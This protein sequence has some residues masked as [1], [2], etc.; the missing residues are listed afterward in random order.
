MFNCGVLFCLLTARYLFSDMSSKNRVYARY[1]DHFGMTGSILCD[2]DNDAPK[3]TTAN[4]YESKIHETH[5]GIQAKTS[6]MKLV[7]LVINTV[8]IVKGIT[9]STTMFT[10][11]ATTESIPDMFMIYGK[12]KI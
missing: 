3:S 5:I 9:G 8:S 4:S 11:S 6:S 12:V 10:K 2:H 1:S 7:R